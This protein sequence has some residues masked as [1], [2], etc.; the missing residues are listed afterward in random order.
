MLVRA[1]VSLLGTSQERSPSLWCLR[2]I[3]SSSWFTLSRRTGRLTV[4]VANSRFHKATAPSLIK[5]FRDCVKQAP[6]ELYANVLLTA[7][8][9]DQ[10]SLVVIQMC[11]VGPKEKGLEYLQAISSWD[12]EPCLLN[13]VNEKAFLNQQDSV[14]QVLRARGLY[15]VTAIRA[16]I[17]M[18]SRGFFCSWKAVVHPFDAHQFAPG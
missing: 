7:G 8:P 15:K 6:R 2:E 1:L 16:T 13:E 3:F 4:P 12:G 17:L 14:A 11:Y 9:A 18:R 10:D 5:H